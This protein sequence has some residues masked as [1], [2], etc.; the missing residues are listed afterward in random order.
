MEKWSELRDAYGPADDIPRLLAQ[1]DP[2]P[3]AEVWGELWVRLCHQ[4]SVYSASFAAIPCLVQA[5]ASWRPKDRTMILSLA[6]AILA[7]D[8]QSAEFAQMRSKLSAEVALLHDLAA[9]SVRALGIPVDDFIYLLQA[10]LALEESTFWATGFDRL[11]GGEF[12]AL[13]PHCG[14]LLYV[15]IGEYGFFT[16]EEDYALNVVTKRGSLD[17]SSPAALIGI[18]RRL[19]EGAI[20]GGH[21]QLA[22]LITYVFGQATCAHCENIFCLP[23]C[24]EAAYD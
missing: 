13:C 6:G 7:G 1:L 2:D 11:A 4:G 15:A 23:E 20:L 22:T 9:E 18:G 21:S 14:A 19:F 5:A 24:I 10:T 17:P 16:S 12:E 8:R 3:R